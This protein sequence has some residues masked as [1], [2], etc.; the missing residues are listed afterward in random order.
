MDG[1]HDLGGLHGFGPIDR[2][3]EEHFPRDWEK[4]V[5]Q[6]TLACGM[7]GKWNLDMSRFARERMD[8]AHY[9]GSSYYEHWYH[10]L[11]T[12]LIEQGLIAPEEIASGQAS[13]D[14]KFEPVP[15]SRVESILRRGGPTLMAEEAPAGFAVGDRV[16]IVNEHPRSHTRMPRYIR[17]RVGEI[18]S[19]HGAHIFPDEHAVSGGKLPRHLYGIRFEGRELWGAESTEPNTVVYVDV[20]EPYIECAVASHD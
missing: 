16:R 19:H 20:F 12:L 3:Q 8:P 14:R 15:A 6:L 18:T 13:G 10:G 2:S 9:L 17:G 1:V 5:F 4:S 11:E 7:L